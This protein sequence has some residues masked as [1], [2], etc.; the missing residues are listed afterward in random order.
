MYFKTVEF[1]NADGIATFSFVI[2][3]CS[4]VIN[5]IT[6][7]FEFK[8]LDGAPMPWYEY[9]DCEECLDCIGATYA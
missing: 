1:K 8:R 5:L 4:L 2:S 6:V 7:F 3:V 9:A